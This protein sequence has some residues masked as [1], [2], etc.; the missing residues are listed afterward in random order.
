MKR[1]FEE[2]RYAVIG[3]PYLRISFQTLFPGQVQFENTI[4]R[5]VRF[6][7]CTITELNT[8]NNNNYDKKYL[9]SGHESFPC[10]TLWLKKG[11]DFIK[12]DKDFNSSDAVIQL[13]VGK[14]M[15]SSIRFWLK[16][17]G[18][19]DDG[20]VTKL[21]DYLFDDANG[22]DRYMEDLTTLWLLHFN[23]V[24]LKRA[25]LYNMLFCG[26]QRERSLFER[27]QVQTYVKLKVAEA[28]KQNAY[29]EN[30]VKKDI[31]VLL[32][33]YVLPK[34]SQSNEDYSSLLMDL[35]LIRQNNSDKGYVFNVEGK[36]K[37]TKEVFMY[38]LLC[39]REQTDDNTIS[40]EAIQ[41]QV[42]LTFCMSENETVSM[43]KQL[44]ELYGDYMS[45]NDVAGI[46][47]IQF[48]KETDTFK[49]LDDYYDKNI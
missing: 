31:G 28:G 33:N 36:R 44:A 11:Y 6:L 9:F 23:L 32:Q 22:R 46:R 5:R 8:M 21:G 24:F 48:T 7:F 19:I 47:Q 42:G 37:V 16:S 17:F 41:D 18:V 2:V 38:G 25:T 35:D 4:R 12:G 14:N 3:V 26:V 1:A 27:E 29:N 15:V 49:V 34:K 45:Y 20:G 43:L 30:T 10:K 13:G 39:L 40:F